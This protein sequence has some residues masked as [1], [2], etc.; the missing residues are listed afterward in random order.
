VV[1]A[2]AVGF[3]S[4]AYEATAGLIGNALLALAADPGLRDTIA[5]DPSRPRRVVH[6]VLRADPPIQS[7]RRVVEGDGTISGREVR[8]GDAVLVLLAAANH[9]PATSPRSAACRQTPPT[10]R[11]HGRDE[12]H[13]HGP[14][15]SVGRDVGLS[16]G[17]GAHVCPG[18]AVAVEISVA[19]VRQVLAAVVSLPE[20]AASFVYRPSA[21]ARVP[22]FVEREG[23]V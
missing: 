8:E 2:N 7:T 5:G 11:D 9:D 12:P 23:A 21:N 10:T 4:Q 15:R 19:A 22:V 20:L 13:S 16:L 1:V 17:A 18:R 14:Q 6:D 3:L